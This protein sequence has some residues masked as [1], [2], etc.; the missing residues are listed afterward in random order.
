[1]APSSEQPARQ[2]P[3][4]INRVSERTVWQDPCRLLF[5]QQGKD[6][7]SGASG[8]VHSADGQGNP[9]TCAGHRRIQVVYNAEG[10]ISGEDDGQ[11]PF[12]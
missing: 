4:G 5:R 10:R 7:A 9:G 3:E 6:E 12:L 1:M 2:S 11:R 8:Y